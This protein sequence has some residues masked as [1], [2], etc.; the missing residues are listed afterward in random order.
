MND[1]IYAKVISEANELL[2]DELSLSEHYRNQTK[3]TLYTVELQISFK[4]EVTRDDILRAD[5][6]V[7]QLSTKSLGIQTHLYNMKDTCCA[8]GRFTYLHYDTTSRSV[9]EFSPSQ[10][11]EISMWKMD[12]EN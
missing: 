9:V 10:L 12:L 3:R 4:S 7:F 6:L 11:E 5:S 2:L 1:A 8:V